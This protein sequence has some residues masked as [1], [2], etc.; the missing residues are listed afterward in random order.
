MRS[1]EFYPVTWEIAKYAG[2]LYSQC[3]TQGNTVG[4]ADATI[5]AVALVNR[6]VLLTDNQKHFP[7]SEINLY[8]MSTS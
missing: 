8:P 3:R 2:E 1:L 4:M 5:A 7:M 6:L